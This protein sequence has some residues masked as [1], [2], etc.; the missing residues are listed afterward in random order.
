MRQQLLREALQP[1]VV[2]LFWCWDGSF[3]RQARTMSLRQDTKSAMVHYRSG[4]YPLNLSEYQ[5]H[6]QD[7]KDVLET[8]S[9]SL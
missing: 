4:R 2:G 9:R 6:A 7:E 5:M 8:R 1:R 3:R